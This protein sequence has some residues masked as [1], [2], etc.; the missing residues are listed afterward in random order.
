M[1]DLFNSLLEE[2]G[3]EPKRV[4]LLRHH[5]DPGI[6]GQSLSDLWNRDPAAF[7][8]YQRTQTANLPLF[9][10]GDIWASFISPEPGRTLFIGL[11]QARHDDTRA[12][13]WSC[14]YRGGAPGAGKPVDVFETSLRSELSNQ[15]GTLEVEWDVRKVRN[16]KRYAHTAPLPIVGTRPV[17]QGLDKTYANSQL[18]TPRAAPQTP[19]FAVGE[20]Y[21]RDQIA[22]ALELSDRQRGGNWL[23]GYSQYYDQFFI[24]ANVGTAGRTGHNY[25]NRWSGKHLIWY[26]KTRTTLFQPEMTKLLSGD[27]PVH[28]FWRAGDR[29]PFTYA[30]LGAP[31]EARDGPPANVTWIFQETTNIGGI[32]LPEKSP[33]RRGPPPAPGERTSLHQDG[34]TSVYLL[35]LDGP[36]SAIF[37]DLTTGSIVVKVGMSND[38]ARRVEDLSCGFPPGCD[39]RWRLTAERSF[40]TGAEAFAV[41]TRLLERLRLSGQAIGGEFA[42]LTEGQLP[43]LIALE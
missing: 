31:L 26:G 8:L 19:L 27:L 25:A 5:T 35:V 12:V 20:R 38:P 43:A 1:A 33:W 4:R 36:I 40:P 15:I 7:E 3:I 39:L 42:V 13:E 10:T 28:I 21:S 32:A 18:A 41:E 9:R 24:F 34:P 14:P 23:T 11:Y 2:V 37:P 22:D 16:W 6:G 29:S 30:G 17:L